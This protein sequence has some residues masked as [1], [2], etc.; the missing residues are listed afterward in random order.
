MKYH[1]HTPAPKNPPLKTTKYIWFLPINILT[2][3][4]PPCGGEAC[5]EMSTGLQET[6]PLLF[7]PNSGL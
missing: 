6:M 3:L 5:L 7:T 1:Q 2:C 4:L